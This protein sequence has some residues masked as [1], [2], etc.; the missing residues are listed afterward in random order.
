MMMIAV[1]S[2]ANQSVKGGFDQDLSLG[3]RE[4]ALA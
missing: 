3:E 1:M 2:K 4:A